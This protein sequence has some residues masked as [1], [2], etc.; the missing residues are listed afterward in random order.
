M[1]GRSNEVLKDQGPRGGGE[2]Q[3]RATVYTPETLTIE[4]NKMKQLVLIIK[5]TTTGAN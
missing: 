4:T 2:I 1:G 5:L 3:G